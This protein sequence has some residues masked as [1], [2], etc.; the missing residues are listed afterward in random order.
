MGRLL[1]EMMDEDIYITPA[2][3][4][5]PELLLLGTLVHH[6]LALELG[7]VMKITAIEY[8][9]KTYK[10]KVEDGGRWYD[11]SPRR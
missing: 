7:T 8:E 3:D 1:N 2:P 4:M 6:E 5:I 11:E 10:I 9:G